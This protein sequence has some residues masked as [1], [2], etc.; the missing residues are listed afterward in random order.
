[1]KD[2]TLNKHN[3]YRSY[4]PIKKPSALQLK[5]FRYPPWP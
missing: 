5:E 3:Q 1:M 2:L 4:K